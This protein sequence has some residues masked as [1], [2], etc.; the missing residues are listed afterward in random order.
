MEKFTVREINHCRLISW[1]FTREE[2]EAL[3]AV[4]VKFPEEKVEA[5]LYELETLCFC[6]KVYLQERDVTFTRTQKKRM[7]RRFEK[8]REE[9]LRLVDH[10][11]KAQENKSVLEIGLL[12]GAI[13]SSSSKMAKAVASIVEE[14]SR[15]YW[16]MNTAAMQLKEIMSIIAI[17]EGDPGRPKGEDATGGLVSAMAFSFQ[18]H[19]EKPSAY[20]YSKSLDTLERNPFF[21]VVQLTLEA[22]GLPFEDP[23]RH[24]K[25]ALKR[26]TPT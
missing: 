13:P 17:D 6:E 20:G 5:F 19:L 1:R 12:S 16:L 23:S 9:L 24:I 21:A 3:Q 18:Y 4:L 25:A 2:R 22:C 7:L 14:E 15:L 26:L 8:A 10:K 11:V